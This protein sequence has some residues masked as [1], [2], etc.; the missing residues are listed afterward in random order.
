MEY[1]ALKYFLIAAK[2]GSITKAANR[3]NLTQPNLSRQISYLERD[4]GKKLFIRSNH[5][6]KLTSEGVL[7]KKR[8]EE[9][10]DLIDKTRTEFKSSEEIIAGD[11]YIGTA[12]TESS[13]ESISKII[14]D[15]QKDY[16][17]IMYHIYSGIYGDVI[18]R[19][20]KGLLDFGILIEPA[21]LS[22]YDY[23]DIPTNEVWG[24]LA[25]RD[26]KIAKKKFVEKKDLIN[27]PLILPTTITKNKSHNNKFLQWFNDD[28]EKLNIV[29]TRNLI[30]SSIVMVKEGIGYS[31][32]LNNINTKDICFIPLKPKLKPRT[33]IVWKKNQIFSPA[34]KIFLEKLCDKIKIKN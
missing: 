15:I 2:E 20:D 8:A 10:M 21:D 12:E 33:N 16:P 13:I 1:R 17:N 23:I 7:L 22:L 32:T 9:I 24:I 19:L 25:R 30:Y 18:E 6:I 28:I 14:K 4:I 34:G 29:L 5:K 27:L 11:I 3:L 31:L 26:S